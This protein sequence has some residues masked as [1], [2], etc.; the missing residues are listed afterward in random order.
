MSE[1]SEKIRV[2]IAEDSNSAQ[3]IIEDILSQ[4]PEIEIVGIA[5]NGKIAVEMN[6]TL[7]PDII[8][9]D[10]NMPVMDGHQAIKEIMGS[11]PKPI[12]VI[13]SYSDAKNAVSAVAAG[14]L[15]LYPK[16]RLGK[17]IKE[18]ITRVKDLSHVK[19]N[20]NKRLINSPEAAGVTGFAP[21]SEG[22][23]IIAVASSTGGPNA[24]VSIFSSFPEDYP[25]PIVVAQHISQGFIHEMVRWMDTIL[26]LNVKVGEQGDVLTPGSIYFSP[27]ENNMEVSRSGM[28]HLAPLDEKAIYHPSCDHLLESVAKNFGANAA[29]IILTGMSR[30]G[31]QGMKQIKAMGGI[32]IAQNEETS[33]IFGMPRVA[34][35]SGCIDYILSP[36]EISNKLI[37]LPGLKHVLP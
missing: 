6:Q 37:S 13:S 21:K 27:S 23:E 28:I 32:T 11:L 12:I 26:K 33:V 17:N 15:E 16:D 3:V 31:V 4:D 34:I 9:M 8:T 20:K 29:G 2:L 19:V 10:L 25:L 1:R 35:E 24:L 7:N 5:E 36:E 14:A 22:T 30:D 18:F